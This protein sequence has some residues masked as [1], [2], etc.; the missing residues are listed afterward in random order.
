MINL[1]SV[2]QNRDISIVIM[3][4]CESQIIKKTEH[5]RTDAF[6]LWCL[7][8]LLRVPLTESRSNQSILKEIKLEYSLKD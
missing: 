8:R 3:Y 7:R 5:Q 6:E 1:D 2:L 4:R